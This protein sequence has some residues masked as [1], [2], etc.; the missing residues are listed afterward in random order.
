[1][2]LK[3][4]CYLLPDT[5]ILGEKSTPSVSDKCF[6]P[7]TSKLQETDYRFG[8]LTRS[9]VTNFLYTARIGISICDVSAQ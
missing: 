1:M 6:G 2:I 7:S 9:M 3:Y 5:G 8:R 4:A